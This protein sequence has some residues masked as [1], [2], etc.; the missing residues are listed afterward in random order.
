MYVIAEPALNP[1]WEYITQLIED[2]DNTD[3][4]ATSEF[5]CNGDDDDTGLK[6]SVSFAPPV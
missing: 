4:T 2:P 1:V 6:Y 5:Y 3:N